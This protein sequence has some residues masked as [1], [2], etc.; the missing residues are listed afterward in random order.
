MSAF[1]PWLA[2]AAGSAIGGTLRYAAARLWPMVPG[3]WPLSTMAVNVLG[4]LAIGVLSVVLAARDAASEVSRL[5]WMI[6]VL[7]GFTTYSTFAIETVYVAESGQ[8]ARAV[9]YAVVTLA[10]CIGA[11]WL[12]RSI[13]GHW[14]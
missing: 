12:G 7:G 6:G 11:A 4:S 1:A 3:G 9:G 10:G 13:A 8:L 2:V 14:Y 5:F